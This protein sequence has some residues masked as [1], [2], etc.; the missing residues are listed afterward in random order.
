M[1]TL[2]AWFCLAAL[3]VSPARGQTNLAAPVFPIPPRQMVVV[4]TKDWQA[5][6]GR[7]QRYERVDRGW[8]AIGPL[9]RIVVG[10]NGMGWGDGLHP[11]PQPGPRKK[12]G[13][14]KSPA[15][16]FSLLYA[17][18]YE[19]AEKVPGIKMPY[20]QCTGTLECVDD[21]NSTHYNQVL[22]RKSVSQ[23]DWHSSEHMRMTNGQYRLGL[24][25][26]HDTSPPVPGD[27]SC[28]FIHIWLGPGIGTSGC[29]AMS[30]G[31]IEALLG[32]I[33]AS[34]NPV[35]VQLPE[36]EYARLQKPWHL[37]PMPGPLETPAQP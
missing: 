7:L 24:V 36:A 16:V 23:P 14:G 26:E 19:P 29:T 32:W 5:V 8:Q 25:I 9:T 13:D 3:V 4:V 2:L 15:G 1:R 10:R 17:F 22:D 18:G 28:V 27:G 35:L 30:D 34:A 11:M 6:N 37:P 20:V 12:E 21:T 33:D 31:N